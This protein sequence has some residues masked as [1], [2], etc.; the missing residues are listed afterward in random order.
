MADS[1]VATIFLGVMRSSSKA[2]SLDRNVG[3]IDRDLK[4][5]SIRGILRGIEWA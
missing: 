5:I 1:Q 3:F 4:R 2:N